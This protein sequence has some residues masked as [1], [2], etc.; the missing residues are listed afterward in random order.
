MPRSEEANI[1]I[2]DD[3]QKQ[4]LCSALKVFIQKGFAAAK[5]S[6][7]AAEAGV[8]YGLMYHYFQSKDE[9]Y[10]ELVRGAIE[11]SRQVLEQVQAEKAEP[12]DKMRTL[13]DRIFASVGGHESA[14][15]YFVLMMG[16]MTSG[17]YPSLALEHPHGPGRPFEMLVHIIEDG[18][19][20]GQIAEGSPAELA[21]TFFS[22]ILGLASLRV[23]GTIQTMP[24]PE[25]LM[26]LFAPALQ[27]KTER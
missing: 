27:A 7:I 13:I 12:I 10:A 23:S 22:A 19:G 18:Q 24:D 17:S 4:I 6:D 14:G 5:M 11:S 15:Y 16:A 20:K 26:R 1:Q 2:K 3:R 25:I 8:S 21:T 9:I